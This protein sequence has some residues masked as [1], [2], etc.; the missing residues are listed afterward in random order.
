MLHKKLMKARKAVEE[1]KN[2]AQ[3]SKEWSYSGSPSC[4]ARQM[5]GTDY[6]NAANKALKALDDKHF[7]TAQEHIEIESQSLASENEDVAV[8]GMV[9][10]YW[11]FR[12]GCGLTGDESE[13]RV[14]RLRNAFWTEHG[15]STVPFRA[16][17]FTGQSQGCEAVHVAVIRF[18]PPQEVHT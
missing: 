4:V 18:S 7:P 14:A 8:F 10:L 16:E 1:L 2:Y 5:L 15:V 11:F 17:Y 6:R 13:V 9:K 12:H 3:D